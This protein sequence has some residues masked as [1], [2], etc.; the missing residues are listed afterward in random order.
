MNLQYSWFM[1]SQHLKKAILS[2][3]K[4]RGLDWW[5][6]F[7]GCPIIFSNRGT[8]EGWYLCADSS[9]GGYG[10]I[11]DLQSPV[12]SS[13]GPQCVLVFWYYMNGFTVGT[14]QVRWDVLL[15]RECAKAFR[16]WIFVFSPTFQVL[17]KY[18]NRSLEVWSQTGNQGN[19]WRRGEVFL[20]LLNNFQVC[21]THACSYK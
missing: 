1:V 18:E 12:I 10:N 7:S 21:K 6:G 13:T 11:T 5:T 4:V 8:P 20:G 3:D 14:L 2:P 9:N 17:L 16:D 15:H 19:K